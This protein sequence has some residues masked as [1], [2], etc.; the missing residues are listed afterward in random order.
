MTAGKSVWD[1]A[2]KTS[3]APKKSPF[4]L[5]RVK[6][7]QP[8]HYGRITLQNA[9]KA[10][11]PSQELAVLQARSILRASQFTALNRIRRGAQ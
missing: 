8:P 1:L 7:D 5:R 6:L 9:A 11:M 2:R 3:D 10:D 4:G